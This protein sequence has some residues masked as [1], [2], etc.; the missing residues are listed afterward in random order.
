MRNFPKVVVAG[1]GILMVVFGLWAFLAPHSFYTGVA[2]FGTYNVHLTHDVG[3]FQTG[4]GVALLAALV[5]NDALVVVLVGGAVG[6]VMHA[7]AH[8]IDR[9]LGVANTKN[10]PYELSALAIIVV[11]AAVTALRARSRRS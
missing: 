4:F 6:T 2:G 5:W 10:E 9:N 7:I 3:A 8:F 1:L 11:I